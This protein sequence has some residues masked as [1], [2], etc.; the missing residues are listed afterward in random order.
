M[1]NTIQYLWKDGKDKVLTF[2]YDDGQIFDRRLVSIFNQY[3][4]KATFHLNSGTLDRD[5][6]IHKDEV[7][8]LYAN[9]EVA[10]HAVTHPYFNQLSADQIMRELYEDRLALEKCISGTVRGLSYPF[11]EYNDVVLQTAKAAGIVYSRTVQDTMQFNIPSEFLLW[12]PTCHHNMVTKEMIEDFLNP[13]EYRTLSLFY[14]WGHS[15]EFERQN[16]WEQIKKI[17]EELQNH[18]DVW[19]ATNM[20]IYEYVCAMRSLI[21]SADGQIIANPTATPL[22]IKIG[23]E[24]VQLLPGMQLDIHSNK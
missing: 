24:T 14:I 1:S 20:E 8:E 15:F 17:C 19:Y 13:P 10:C 9:H 5:G 7:K 11:G 2:S 12:H 6:F 3:N 22:W 21:T 16:N 18:E 4:M 23:K